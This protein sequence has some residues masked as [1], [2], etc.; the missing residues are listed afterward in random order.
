MVKTMFLHLSLPSN[1]QRRSK[2]SCF[3]ACSGISQTSLQSSQPLTCA[4]DFVHFGGRGILWTF[5]R[6]SEFAYGI[7]AKRASTTG[8]ANGSSRFD[9]M[10]RSM[11]VSP[12]LREE[13][14]H[15]GKQALTS[16]PHPRRQALSPSVVGAGFR[17]LSHRVSMAFNGSRIGSVA[18]LDRLVLYDLSR[19]AFL[20]LSYCSSVSSRMISP[21]LVR[22]ISSRMLGFEGLGRRHGV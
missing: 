17:S 13:Y 6:P 19:H 21:D 1:D 16:R 10:R 14:K 12:R 22:I 20:S 3:P 18:E 4:K 9:C 5:G 8:E 7:P 11:S 2:L 15:H